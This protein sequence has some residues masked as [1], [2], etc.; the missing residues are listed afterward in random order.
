MNENDTLAESLLRAKHRLYGPLIDE[1]RNAQAFEQW[2]KQLPPRTDKSQFSSDDSKALLLAKQEGIVTLAA[3]FS[4]MAS[5]SSL[6]TIG[7]VL[8]QG[9]YPRDLGTLPFLGLCR[10]SLEGAVRTLWVLTADNQS[11]RITRSFRLRRIELIEHK[12]LTERRCERIETEGAL[13]ETT[14]AMFQEI[15]ETIDAIES[16]GLAKIKS[17][18]QFR[19]MISDIDIW[20]QS[21][22]EEL[23]LDILKSSFADRAIEAYSVSSGA[24]HGLQWISDLV[25][26]PD[27]IYAMSLDIFTITK[28][29]L[30]LAVSLV[31][32]HS[33]APGPVASRNTVPEYLKSFIESLPK[34]EVWERN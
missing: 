14:I 21:L 28:L 1:V 4:A 20:I 18:I 29:C 15:N 27:D 32:I 5:A 30:E 9:I 12:R 22:P 19:D 31:E 16:L 13:L 24:I 26:T 7:S 3:V 2:S 11:E 10:A 34:P 33:S 17:R 25:S 23:E 8:H 6:S